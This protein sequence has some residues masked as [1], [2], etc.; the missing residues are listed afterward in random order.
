MESK[1]EQID[2]LAQGLKVEGAPESPALPSA[3]AC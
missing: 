1:I 3:E 2:G